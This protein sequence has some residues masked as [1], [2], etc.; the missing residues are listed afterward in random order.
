MLPAHIEP[1]LPA[2]GADGITY[3]VAAVV[4]AVVLLQPFTVAVTL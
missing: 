3:T 2:V 1:P 4:P